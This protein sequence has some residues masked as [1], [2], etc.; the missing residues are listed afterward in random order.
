MTVCLVYPYT[1]LIIIDQGDL[2]ANSFVLPEQLSIAQAQSASSL[3]LHIAEI[4]YP[5]YYLVKVYIR[6]CIEPADSA[7]TD[8]MSLYLNPRSVASWSTKRDIDAGCRVEK[9]VVSDVEII[10]DIVTVPEERT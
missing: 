9:V 10:D 3:A 6:G 2:A 1:N 5:I 4:Q 8:I 7:S